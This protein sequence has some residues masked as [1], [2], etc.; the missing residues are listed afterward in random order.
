MDERNT[1]W[2]VIKRIF[3]GQNAFLNTEIH[4][5]QKKRLDDKWADDYQNDLIEDK[6]L[7]RDNPLDNKVTPKVLP[8]N[9]L[10]DIRGRK[11]I[12]EITYQRYNDYVHGGRMTLWVQIQNS[13]SVR[14]RMQ[15]AEV[16][17][18]RRDIGYC[19]DPGQIQQLKIYDGPLP[20]TTAYR[21][22]KLVYSEMHS[23]VRDTFCA[24]YV[25]L[26]RDHYEKGQYV[27]RR[28]IKNGPTQDW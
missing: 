7:I 5:I 14:L 11:I 25:A 1:P 16:F 21:D 3:S 10:R 20:K 27:L 22:V 15:R 6:R 4:L 24:R 13:S 17:N 19:I 28:L 26:F 12:P 18:I 2:E 8:A 23:G 9:P